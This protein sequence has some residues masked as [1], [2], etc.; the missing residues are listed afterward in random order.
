MK[1]RL[2]LPSGQ[3]WCVRNVRVLDPARQRD[4]IADVLSFEGRRVESMPPGVDPVVVDGTGWMAMPSLIDLHVHFREPGGEGSE[5]CRTGSAAAVRGG[6]AVL[7]TMPNTTP[8]VDTPEAV[9]FQAET[10]LFPQCGLRILPSACCTRGR[11]GVVPADLE[12][13]AAAGARAFTDDGAMV[14]DDA[15]MEAVMRRVACL[16]RVVMDHA[17]VPAIAGA[18]M[19]RACAVAREHGLPVF[20]PEA[21]TTAVSRDIE[22]CRRTG[23][24]IHIQHLSCA[25]SVSLI[26]EA[27]AE[28][29]PV[30]AEATPHHLMLAA[31]DIPGNDANWKMNPPLGT[32][33]D[34]AALRQ[35]VMDGVIGCLATDHAPHAPATKA[36]GFAGAPFGVIGLETALAAT[37]TALVDA[38]GMAPLDWAAR[39]L[40]GPAGVLGIPVPTVQWGST[41]PVTLFKP[42]PW[43]VSRDDIVSKSC[44][45]PFL[46]RTLGA[47]VVGLLN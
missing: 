20:P 47:C 23:C 32:R 11:A 27:Q 46:G 30:T 14:A 1:E 38:A 33:N 36:G 25:G 19:I 15:V 40:C 2:T 45:S 17:V 24:A 39:W 16:G 31:E 10:P 18:G 22:C 37:W 3:P 43:T 6:V 42:G 35:G 28:G 41:D 8:P 13:L 9:R 26:R 21:E 29:L 34:M 4:T 5:T 44:N 12:A 7:V